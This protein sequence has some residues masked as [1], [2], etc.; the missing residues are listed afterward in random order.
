MKASFF[1][2]LPAIV[3]AAATPQVKERQVPNLLDPACLLQ[4][5]D[6]STCLP[7]LDLD[8]VVKF[9][10]ILLCPIRIIIRILTECDA[11]PN[12]LK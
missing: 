2:A 3:A 1:L 5:S 9:D 10:D 7:N 12:L 8:S 4:V 6:I 11:V